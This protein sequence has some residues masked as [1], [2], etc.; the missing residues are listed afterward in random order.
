M[1]IIFFLGES[2]VPIKSLCLKMLVLMC[3]GND[4]IAQNP[5]YEYLM[6]HSIFESLVNILCQTSGNQL[7]NLKFLCLKY[8][9][10]FWLQGDWSLVKM[11]CY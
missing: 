2:P 7:F 4:N 3:S 10:I 1:I 5:F 6:Q 11:L 8:N 9:Y